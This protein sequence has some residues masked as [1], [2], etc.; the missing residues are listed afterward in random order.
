MGEGGCK[1][2]WGIFL[3]VMEQ[4]H[5]FM[6]V[7]VA[8]PCALV[9]TLCIIQLELDLIVCKLYLYKADF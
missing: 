3:G 9:K 5:I 6:I 8:Q 2:T 4:L 1:G 7:V